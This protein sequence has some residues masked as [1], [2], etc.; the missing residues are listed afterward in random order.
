MLRSFDIAIIGGGIIGC[1][2]AWFLAREGLRVVVFERS[3]IAAEASGASAGFIDYA[4]G[5]SRGT[6][7]FAQASI[8]LLCEAAE[9][10][11]D[12]E[13][14]L[15]GCLTLAVSEKELPRLR[16]RYEAGRAAGLRVEL[17]DGPAAR[18]LEPSLSAQTVLSALYQRDAGHVDPARM[19]HAFACGAVKRRAQFEVGIE[20]TDLVRLGK[21]ANGI[22]TSRGRFGA[23]HIVLAAGAWSRNFAS[24]VGVKLQLRPAKGQML[25]TEPVPRFTQRVFNS[26]IA[27]LRQ[28]RKGEV[29]IGSTLEYVGFDKTVDPKVVTALLSDAT[30]LVP[31][32]RA[33]RISRSWAGLRPMTPDSLPIIGQP[34][35]LDRFWL[36]TGHSRTGFTYAAGT[37]RAIADLITRGT[38]SLPVHRFAPTR[39][40]L[41]MG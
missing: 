20:V 15:E 2:C 24:A 22:I 16:E 11:A 9:E 26:S 3:H 39:F 17:L 4:E 32:L 18:A 23:E 37:G 13:L 5:L 12:F 28:N 36:A 27:G 14:T 40:A 8:G 21:T 1:T 38:T 19:T 6:L 10:L 30:R 29:I 31:A 25:A 33:A 34:E 35:G 7:D 41:A